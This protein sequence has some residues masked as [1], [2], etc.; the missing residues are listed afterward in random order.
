[1]QGAREDWIERLG[2][3][4]DAQDTLSSSP[5]QPGEKVP[6]P[7]LPPPLPLGSPHQ[8]G[9]GPNVAETL[10]CYVS[11]IM[12]LQAW[13]EGD[14]DTSNDEPAEFPLNLTDCL[15]RAVAGCLGKMQNQPAYI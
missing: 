11:T 4:A 9:N 12:C 7:P 1:M 15:Q 14:D 5:E 10:S 13:Y 6:H 3:H 8:S 2:R